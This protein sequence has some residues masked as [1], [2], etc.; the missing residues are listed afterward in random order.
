M[1]YKLTKN[2]GGEI[3]LTINMKFNTTEEATTALLALEQVNHSPSISQLESELLVII[4][5]QG[6]IP[7]VK[8]YKELS[9]NPLKESKEFCD[10]V[11][12][13]LVRLKLL[14]K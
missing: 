4:K 7:A 2:E 1:N 5:N 14:D 9:G 10:E 3:V 12:A 13:K 8:Y 6:F 11:K